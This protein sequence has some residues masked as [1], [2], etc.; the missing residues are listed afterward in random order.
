MPWMPEAPSRF[1]WPSRTA[2]VIV[3]TGPVP[4]MMPAILLEPLRS[5]WAKSSQGTALPSRAATAMCPSSRGSRGGRKP[6]AKPIAIRTT[7]PRTSRTK[8]ISTG[9]NAYPEI[10]IH[11]NTEPQSRLSAL[12]RTAAAFDMIVPLVLEASTTGARRNAP[13][14]MRAAP[15]ERP[16][17]VRPAG[18]IAGSG[19]ELHT[20]AP[21][22][23]IEEFCR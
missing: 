3:H 11:R 1:S 4:L 22:A 15:S 16:Y 21:G 12:S 10:L 6:L 23:S 19:N 7:A 2:A 8:T 14:H 9:E 13:E 17:R 18:R 20:G 5:P